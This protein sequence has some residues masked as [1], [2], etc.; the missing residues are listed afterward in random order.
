[1]GPIVVSRHML[2]WL[3]LL[4][5]V[6]VAVAGCTATPT[7]G[8]AAPDHGRSASPAGAAAVPP[9][10]HL[11]T[12][13]TY[14]VS[15]SIPGSWQPTPGLGPPEGFGYDGPSGWVQ[16]NAMVEP[17]GLHYACTVAAT[18]NVVHP[19]G[20]HPQIIYHSIDGRPGC[21][22]FPSQSAPALARR[23]GG[24]AFEGS[25]ALVEYRR[26]VGAYALLVVDADP[27]HLVAIAYSIELHH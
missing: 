14:A 17:S 23:A 3:G 26:P 4:A 13:Q 27:A 7:S 1:M 25:E 10:T 18:G 22:I 8:A 2:G 20:L 11:V 15:I 6:A 12:S 16:L 9:G 5:T 24:P 21:L 19:Y